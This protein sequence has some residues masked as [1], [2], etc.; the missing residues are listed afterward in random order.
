MGR[1]AHRFVEINHA[2]EFTTVAN[3][4]VDLLPNLFRPR[5][6]KAVF[7]KIPPARDLP[8][9]G[10]MCQRCHCTEQGAIISDQ[11]ELSANLWVK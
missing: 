9:S 8:S 11:T 6:V 10:H 4:G 3:P 7:A 2:V 1:V 5:A